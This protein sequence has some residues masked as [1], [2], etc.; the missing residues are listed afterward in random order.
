MTYPEAE[1]YL[2]TL[3][4]FA[5]KGAAAYAPGLD[6]ISA[7]L[8]A[9]GQPH[10]RYP[11]V[12]IAGTNGKGSTAS[13]LAAIA[14]ASGKKTGLHTSPHLYHVAERMRVNGKPAPETWMAAA[15]QQYR[16]VFTAARVS[17]FEATVALSLLYF[18]SQAVDLA[19]VEV[20]LGGRLDATNIVSPELV[21]ITAIGLDHTQI[22]GNSI[23][24]ITREK[25]GI[26]K[27]GVP[28]LTGVTRQDALQEI[29]M[30]AAQKAAPLTWLDD[31]IDWSV[32]KTSPAGVIIN[33][34]T[35]HREYTRLKVG[36]PGRHQSRNAL[37]ALLAAEIL[38]ADQ[39]EGA[40]FIS[41]GLAQVV[42]LSGLRGRLEVVQQEPLI[43][44]DVGHNHD[45]LHAALAS[46]SELLMERQ[47][48]LFVMF[49][50]MN[51]KNVREMAKQLADAGARVF[52]PPIYAERALPS[53]ELVQMLRT[54]NINA[55]RVSSFENG[56]SRFH[57]E[58][59]NRDGLL[60]VGSH[61]L[62]AQYPG[63][64][65]L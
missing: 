37:L 58:A 46:M 19:I 45:G 43:I 8:E 44:L 29:K 17:F 60:I 53:N 34:V 32:I 24:E 6:R 12:H 61:L 63:M 62:A 7:V 23:R 54:Q 16:E 51:D 36:L 4:R 27:A 15:V 26:I 22:L 56:L 47:G 38:F 65:D 2:N 57:E 35:A 14:T 28:V 21:I 5:I 11:I 18:A 33:A 30:A 40:S 3:P 39:E 59:T 10:T 20:G 42:A 9:M 31:A 50:T 49:G 48:Q 13:F 25:A 1:A 52:A 55:T 64:T 41:A